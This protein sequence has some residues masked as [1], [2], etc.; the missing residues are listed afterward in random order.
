G[1]V[2]NATVEGEFDPASGK[3]E[4]NVL[5]KAAH[6]DATLGGTIS[7]SIFTASQGSRIVL[8]LHPAAVAKLMP[9][10]DS[11]DQPAMVLASPATI[12]ADLMQLVLP[13]KDFQPADA[14]I[15]ARVSVD[16]FALAGDPRLADTAVRDLV[17]DL[18]AVRL[19]QPIAA[20]L[21]GQLQRGERQGAID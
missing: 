14:T 21:K 12:T 15:G 7:N 9:P 5:A 8:T 2:L 13:L 18:P 11:G 17:V 3:G 10:P 6:L 19:D 16:Q 4:L 1:P 20:T